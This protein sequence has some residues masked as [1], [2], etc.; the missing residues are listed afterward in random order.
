MELTPI[1]KNKLEN[2]DIDQIDE[3]SNFPISNKDIIIIEPTNSM[4]I[5]IRKFLMDLGFEN[6]HVCKGVKE[7]SEIFFDFTDF[8]KY[9]SGFCKTALKDIPDLILEI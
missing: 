6:I 4:I 3:F 8:C 9:P 7:G 1:E 5:T 2:R